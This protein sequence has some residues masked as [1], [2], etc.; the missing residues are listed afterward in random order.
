MVSTGPELHQHRTE[1]IG[2][3]IADRDRTGEDQLLLE[4]HAGVWTTMHTSGATYT[5]REYYD[6]RYTRAPDITYLHLDTAQHRGLGLAA[7]DVN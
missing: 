5:Y 4:S 3:H 7:A 1:G 2:A 6:A